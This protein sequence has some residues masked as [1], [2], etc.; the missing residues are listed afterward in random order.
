M[1]PV[2][3]ALVGGII[4]SLIGLFALLPAFRGP[5]LGL[6]NLVIETSYGM[7]LGLFAMNVLNKLMLI[8]FGIWGIW[9]SQRKNR[10]L[11]A[12][13]QFSRGV[14]YAFGALAILGLLNITNTLLGYAPLFGAQILLNSA[15]AACG[16]YFGY[17][18]SSQVPKVTRGGPEDFRSPAHGTR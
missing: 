15:F 9:A 11:P 13:I 1:H 16:A 4:M 5:S 3:F 10:E 18:L 8:G 12:S 6:P 2:R 17:Y 14:M 7:F